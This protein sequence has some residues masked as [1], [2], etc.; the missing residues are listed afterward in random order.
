M[1]IANMHLTSYCKVLLEG[2][3]DREKADKL[4]GSILYAR[5]DERPEVENDEYYIS[6]GLLI[7]S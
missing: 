2:I 3:T 6:V 1:V 5:E 7:N 4:K